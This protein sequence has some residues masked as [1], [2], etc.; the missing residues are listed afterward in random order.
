MPL[1]EYVCDKC[2]NSFETMLSVAEGEKL[3]GTVCDE[4]GKGP[5]R[6]AIGIPAVHMRYSPMHPRHMRGQK[7]PAKP[8]KSMPPKKAKK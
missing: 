7:G 3:V 5:L 4:C 2:D 1:Y 6:R 8:R